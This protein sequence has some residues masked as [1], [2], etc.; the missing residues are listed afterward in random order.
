MADGR[1]CFAFRER[2]REAEGL[3]REGEAGRTQQV[4]SEVEG[5]VRYFNLGSGS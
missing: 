3:G 4:L 1:A 5:R 2:G